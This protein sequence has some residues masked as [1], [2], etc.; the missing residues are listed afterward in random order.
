MEISNMI[1]LY[2][3]FILEEDFVELE[4]WLILYNIFSDFGNLFVYVILKIN[5]LKKI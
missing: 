3:L 5:I 2:Q 1:N 4:Q